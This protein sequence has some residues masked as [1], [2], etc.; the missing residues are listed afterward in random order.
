MLCLWSL[1]ACGHIELNIKIYV[2]IF[3]VYYVFNSNNN[4]WGSYSS[5]VSEV[6]ALRILWKKAFGKYIN[7][8]NVQFQWLASIL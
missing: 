8:N 2:K 1:T 5:Y 7:V 4:L 6:N 3:R